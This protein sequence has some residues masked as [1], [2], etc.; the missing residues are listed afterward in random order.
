MRTRVRNWRSIVFRVLTSRPMKTAILLWL[1]LPTH[2]RSQTFVAGAA[3]RN[4]ALTPS[5]TFAVEPGHAPNAVRFLAAM[6]RDQLDT[7]LCTLSAMLNASEA[8]FDTTE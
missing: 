8:D 1:T 7:G 5:M 4:I 2:W 6:T 3:R